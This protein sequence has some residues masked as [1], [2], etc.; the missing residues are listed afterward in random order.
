MSAEEEHSQRQCIRESE[1]LEGFP[2][3][4]D[5]LST[6]INT[7]SSTNEN[8]RFWCQFLKRHEI[9]VDLLGGDYEGLWQ[10][11]LDTM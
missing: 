8:F 6:F 2:T 4:I 10:L 9:T 11:H 5:D 1:N 3:P 7:R